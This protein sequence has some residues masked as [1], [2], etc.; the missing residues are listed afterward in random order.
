MFVWQI[1]IN[2]TY[3]KI[4]EG[5]D[6]VDLVDHAGNWPVVV[7]K[8]FVIF[9]PDPEGEMIQFDLRIVFKWLA[10]NRQLVK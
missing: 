4:T 6:L 10:K 2:E 9:T 7:S 5:A 8:I 3:M 1:I